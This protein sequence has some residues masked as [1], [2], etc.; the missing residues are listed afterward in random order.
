[1]NNR[2]P[3]NDIG[4]VVSAFIMY[5]VSCTNMYLMAAIAV[6]RYLIVTGKLAKR[7]ASV[8]ARVYVVL[9]CTLVALFWACM[10]LVGWSRYS[11]ERAHTSCSVEYAERSLSVTTYIV[12]VFVFVFLA[13]LSQIAYS[14]VR[15]VLFVNKFFRRKILITKHQAITSASSFSSYSSSVS[16]S[17]SDKN[18]LASGN[19][20]ELFSKS[21]KITLMMG[22]YICESFFFYNYSFSSIFV[23]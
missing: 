13:P 16:S 7:M 6:E 19:T 3:F 22:I 15:L 4:C 18:N 5:F 20:R 12:A 9:G 17:T 1:M 11:M 10:P 2:W 14:T 8:L 21:L 23:Y